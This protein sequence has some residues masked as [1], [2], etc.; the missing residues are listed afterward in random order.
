VAK[1]KYSKFVSP[2]GIAK[3]AWLN[4]PDDKFGKE[5]F[6][7]RVVIEDNEANRE[8]CEK[9]FEAGKAEA[10][11][12]G[13][14]LK[15]AAKSPFNYPEDQDEDDYVAEEGKDHPKLDEDHQGAI[16]FEAK[17]QFQ[18]GLIDSARQS[19]PD[20]VQIRGGDKIRVKIELN[21]YEGFGSGVSLR[22]KTAQ[23]VEKNTSFSGGGAD[24]DGFDDVEDGYVADQTSGDSEDGD[25]DEDF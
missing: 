9:V 16:F 12:A 17:T 7:V 6:K 3:F 5:E 24:T 18:P 15:K 13:V 8:W 1:V 14:K 20:D 21:P 23:L 19:L 11:K 4:K 22:L 10:K 25:E 2:I